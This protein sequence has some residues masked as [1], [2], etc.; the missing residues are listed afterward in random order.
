MA[1]VQ[2]VEGVALEQEA[3]VEV[4]GEETVDQREV[5]PGQQILYLGEDLP[6]VGEEALGRGRQDAP[7]PVRLRVRGA[8]RV[9]GD[10]RVVTL[11]EAL[12]ERVVRRSLH[13][14]GPGER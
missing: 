6:R 10:H 5:L 11:A 13:R 4:E 7:R 12:R 3:L 14:A 1:P 8:S 9:I 2:H